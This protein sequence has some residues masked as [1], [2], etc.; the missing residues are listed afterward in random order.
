MWD[1]KYIKIGE[2]E[3][4]IKFECLSKSTRSGFYH[5]CELSINGEYDTFARVSYLNR[6]WE[7]FTYQSAMI[8]AVRKSSLS[9]EEKKALIKQL[10]EGDLS[11]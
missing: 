10:V 8:A 2:E 11:W 3:K 1:V 6:T 4:S 7:S 5:R 9:V